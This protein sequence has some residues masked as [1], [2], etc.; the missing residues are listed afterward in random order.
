[1]VT[2]MKDYYTLV[3]YRVCKMIPKRLYDAILDVYVDS[4][5]IWIILQNGWTA[6]NMDSN[7][8]TIHVGGEDAGYETKEVK[9]EIRYQLKGIRRV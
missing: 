3:L 9:E 5:G 1:M 4:D 8:R 7:C 2:D 6:G